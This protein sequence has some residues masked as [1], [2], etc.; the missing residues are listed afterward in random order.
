MAKYKVML[1][2]EDFTNG[3]TVQTRNGWWFLYHEGSFSTVTGYFG[4]LD[5]DENLRLRDNGPIARNFDIMKICTPVSFEGP[6]SSILEYHGDVI[7][8][9]QEQDE[10]D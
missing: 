10:N 5:I 3:M 6:L 8:E 9:R 1:D 2:K 7:W 4:L